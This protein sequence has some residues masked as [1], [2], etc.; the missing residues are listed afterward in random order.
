MS[1]KYI[2]IELNV[3][4]G[5]RCIHSAKIWQV[6]KIG[7]RPY[8]TFGI[9]AISP[10]ILQG[11]KTGRH[12]Y[13]TIYLAKQILEI[14]FRIGYIEPYRNNF[15]IQHAQP[16]DLSCRLYVRHGPTHLVTGK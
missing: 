14:I 1:C 6:N 13:R 7:A 2:Y 10:I 4:V 11:N 12:V 16:P 8:S 5:I 15:H 9:L 3:R